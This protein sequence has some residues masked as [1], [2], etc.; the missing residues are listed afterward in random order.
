M[1]NESP[2]TVIPIVMHYTTK[3]SVSYILLYCLYFSGSGSKCGQYTM[4]STYLLN[5]PQ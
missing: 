1:L 3:Q 4:S 2:K 5:L